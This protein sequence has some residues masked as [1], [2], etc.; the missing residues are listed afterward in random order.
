MFSVRVLVYCREWEVIDLE[1]I[2]SCSA[3][4]VDSEDYLLE[5]W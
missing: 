4:T 2:G 5:G 3:I 1:K